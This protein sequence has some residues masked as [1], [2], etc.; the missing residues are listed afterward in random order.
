[1]GH[2]ARFLLA[3]AG[4][5]SV[6]ALFSDVESLVRH[7]T[8]IWFSAAWIGNPGLVLAEKQFSTPVYWLPPVDRPVATA[9][10]R[11]TWQNL[12]RFAT[13]TAASDAPVR[14]SHA[15]E[16]S[17][18]S[19]TLNG[20]QPVNAANY[21]DGI[22]LGTCEWECLGEGECCFDLVAIMSPVTEGWKLCVKQ[23]REN[24]QC[25]CVNILYQAGSA[26]AV[27]ALAAANRI[28]DL[29]GQLGNVERCCPVIRVEVHDSAISAADWTANIAPSLTPGGG[30]N[31]AGEAQLR[32]NGFGHLARC[33]NFLIVPLAFPDGR[34]GSTYRP[35]GMGGRARGFGILSP[36]GLAA[37]PNIAGHEAGHALDLPDVPDDD[38]LMGPHYPS[39]VNLTAPQ[40]ETIWRNLSRYAC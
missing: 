28:A 34:T 37:D 7:E 36:A 18:L 23:K 16:G 30:A 35:D 12:A 3:L 29:I 15:V 33:I 4:H 20:D 5:G 14:V 25:I 40:C 39:G 9:T 31:L 24:T 13:F 32:D 2:E 11:M 38:N 22:F 8:T 21:P 19:I 10:V 26:S 27:A 6:N 17:R 1:V